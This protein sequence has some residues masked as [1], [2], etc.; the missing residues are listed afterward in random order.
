MGTGDV[1]IAGAGAALCVDIL[2]YPLDTVKTRLQSPRFRELYARNALPSSVQIDYRKLSRGLYQGVGSVV[3]ATVPSGMSIHDYDD[4]GLTTAGA[5][6]TTYEGAKGLLGSSPLSQPLVHGLASVLGEL[7][8]CVILTPAE[9]L[10]QNAQMISKTTGHSGRVFDG[11]ATLLALRKFNSPRQLWQGYT[12]L[13]GRNL[14][15]TAMH[16][17]LF[18]HLRTL[19]HARR[20]E[21]GQ[22]SGSLLETAL[23]TATA[24]ASAGSLAAVITTPIDVVKTRIMLSAADQKS[25]DKQ[26]RFRSWQI[27]KSVWQSEGLSG[28]FR[29][30]ALRGSW[31]ALG[32]GLYLGV[33]ESGRKYLENRP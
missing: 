17:P 3:L 18:E 2:V 1:L 5:F 32:S 30:G 15:F 23:V 27:G 21:R 8:S 22:A 24:A 10:K 28:L 20:S 16:F 12:A 26:Q 9:V 19:I 7:V 4:A 29:G 33:Y 13:A 25:Y 14:P 11:N 31:T 6:F